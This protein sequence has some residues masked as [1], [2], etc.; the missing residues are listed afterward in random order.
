ME[1]V[2]TANRESEYRVVFDTARLEV[3]VK[4]RERL[5]HKLF[6]IGEKYSEEWVTVYDSA[7]IEQIKDFLEDIGGDEWVKVTMV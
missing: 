2:P 6:G 7:P 4:Q 1:N 5:L 3:R